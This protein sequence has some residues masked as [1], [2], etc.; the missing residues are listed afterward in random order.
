LSQAGDLEIKVTF[1]PVAL[2]APVDPPSNYTYPMPVYVQSNQPMKPVLTSQGPIIQVPP[3]SPVTP[4]GGSEAAVSTDVIR[5]TAIQDAPMWYGDSAAMV[6]GGA[7]F[8]ADG[9]DPAGDGFSGAVRLADGT[10][11]VTDTDLA[12]GGYGMPWGHTRTW[13]NRLGLAEKTPNGNGW[14]ISQLPYLLQGSSTI[15]E[16][17]SGR[18]GRYFDRTSADGVSPDGSRMGS[19]CT[20]ATPSPR[21]QR[22]DDGPVLAHRAPSTKA[23]RDRH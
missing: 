14:T 18:S 23:P 3:Y 16:V 11:S 13:T 17:A 5:L 1:D 2:T 12:S 8:G 9:G 6:P 20:R 15:V 19:G 22:S 10:V 7:A 4:Q 21:G